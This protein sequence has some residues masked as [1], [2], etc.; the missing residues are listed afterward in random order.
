L[1]PGGSSTVHIYTQAVHRIQRTE[2]TLLNMI[3][4]LEWRLAELKFGKREVVAY[5]KTLK[6]RI[7]IS[8]DDVGYPEE[9]PPPP[10]HTEFPG[11]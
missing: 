8:S 11:T 4:P 10:A 3:V 1:T 5:R 7:S 2:H 9:P 6:I